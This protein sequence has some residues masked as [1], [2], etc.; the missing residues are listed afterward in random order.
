MSYQNGTPFVNL[1][2][3]VGTDKRD[4]ADTN[5]A[6]LD[7][8]G[9]LKSAYN[10][11]IDTAAAL[12]ALTEVVSGIS[13]DV[14]DLQTTVGS[15]TTSIGTINEALTLINTALTSLN[16]TVT[17]KFDSAG[18]ADPY[19]AEHGIY[20]IGNVVTYNGQR[21]VCHVAV[22]AAEPFDADKWTAVDIQAELDAIHA[23]LDEFTQVELFSGSVTTGDDITLSEHINNCRFIVVVDTNLQ[24]ESATMINSF[25]NK[26][27]RGLTI[28][29][30]ITDMNNTLTPA[31]LCISD[32]AM[33]NTDGI[34][35]HVE[36]S[37]QINISSTGVEYFAD[38]RTA[39][40]SIYGYR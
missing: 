16:N 13:S 6:F 34:H 30:G 5:E 12:A 3:T 25:Y 39:S 40:I 8:D 4:W 33:T 27:G 29:C 26:T 9:K 10:G 24:S 15:H 11:A 23:D 20:D 38:T 14:S 19:D 7:L 28:N 22:T 1:P 36:R 32:I 21:Y 31:V 18:V 2:Q 35:Y 17:G 37:G